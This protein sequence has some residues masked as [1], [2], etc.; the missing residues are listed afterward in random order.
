MSVNDSPMRKKTVLKKQLFFLILSGIG[1]FLFN[2]IFTSATAS[3][4]VNDGSAV[5]V[6]EWSN[7]RIVNNQTS[8]PSTFVPTNSSIEWSEFRLHYPAHITLGNCTATL[9]LAKAGTGGGTV[10]SSP[11]GINCGTTCTYDFT[12]GTS[13]VLTAAANTSSIFSGWSGGGCSGTGTC[14]VTMNS[15]TTVTATFDLP[16]LTV[17]KAGAGSGTVT[18][19]PAG[20]NCGSTC[21]YAYN[22]GTA[23]VLTAA[24]SGGS[25]FGG[26]SGGGCSGTGTCTVT[27][28]SAISITA[29]FNVVVV[30]VRGLTAVTGTNGKIYIFGGDYSTGAY[31]DEYDAAT[32]TYVAKAA[33]QNCG[34]G[35]GAAVNWGTGAKI[36]QFSGSS[37]T[38]PETCYGINREYDITTNTWTSKAA[39]PNSGRSSSAAATVSNKTYVIGGVANGVVFNYNYQFDPATNTWTAK[40]NMPTARYWTSGTVY[41][42]QIYVIG[43]NIPGQ[44]TP[45]NA[46]ERYDPS[47]NTWL[48][49]AVLPTP[50]RGMGIVTIGSYIYCAG[51]DINVA[52]PYVVP[53]LE[54]YDPVAN[55]WTAKAN[56][57]TGRESMS[58]AVGSNGKMYTFGGANASW[59]NTRINEEYDPATDTWTAKGTFP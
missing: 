9:T 11:A 30:G 19:N 53:K 47:S 31:L 8:S 29:T 39:I 37:Y 44:G 25:T 15:V 17:T 43:G 28:N 5:T 12:I 50:R 6:N 10:T 20:I 2:P 23:V 56:M 57:I 41:N 24:A 40:A 59:A 33:P 21:S 32:N 42:N 26:W 48:A 55:T 45:P 34:F 35:A 38:T 22:K 13:V 58:A 36:Y 52:Y 18:S 7:C 51:G 1:F 3:Y 46:N 4:Q 16:L 27:M 49:R 54:R 14:T